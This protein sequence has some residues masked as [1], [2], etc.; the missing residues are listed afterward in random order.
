MGA[1]IVTETNFKFLIHTGNRH[2]DMLP[3][4]QM[5]TIVGTDEGFDATSGTFVLDGVLGPTRSFRERNSLALF[6]NRVIF[7]KKER[8]LG[9]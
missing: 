8:K 3:D 9:E 2:D 6:G 4:G 5:V 1:E 7:A